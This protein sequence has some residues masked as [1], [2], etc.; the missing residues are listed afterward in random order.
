MPIA[1]IV[2]YLL[3]AASTASAGLALRYYLH[4]FQLN[5]YRPGAQLRWMA[6]NW[7]K[8]LLL[9]V[10]VAGGLFFWP[11]KAVKKPLVCTARVKRLLVTAALPYVLGLALPPL[12]KWVEYNVFHRDIAYTPY[13]LPLL[14]QF[15]YILVAPLA[16][17]F[18]LLVANLVNA[19]I[20]HA[21]RQHYINEAKEKLKNSPNLTV[22][23]IT[24]SYGKTSVK[25]FL[26]TL[27]RARFNVL[28]TPGGANVPM[29]VV[30]TVR[31]EL[32]A[33]HEIFICEMGA[34]YVGDIEELCG[35][36]H[37]RHG[38]LTSI[39][40]QHLETFGSQENVISTK[41]ELADA[42]PPGGILFANGDDA[43]IRTKLNGYQNV[44]TYAPFENGSDYHAE[45]IIADHRG[46]TFT[47]V[48]P[49]G[50]RET[51]TARLIGRHNVVNLVGAAAAA[52]TLGV[53]LRALKGQM[54]KIAPVR[55]RL[56]LLDKGGGLLVIDDAYNSN[57]TG[58]KAA[59]DALALFEGTKVL[60]TPGMIEL[61]PKQEE[62]NRKFGEQAA[63]VCDYIALVGAAQ[64]KPIREG[65]LAAG[66]AP[67]RLIVEDTLQAAM[68][69]VTA[70]P[71]DGR[72][73]ILLEN[74]LP[75]NY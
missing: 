4:M 75:D 26:H 11:R 35:I 50:E 30:R 52:H 45:D 17:P 27:L 57:P 44:V 40:P 38:I 73:I 41:F 55:H 21:I 37:P 53:P 61:G 34:K 58:A 51:F 13:L 49:Q 23:G 9:C 36:V 20:E 28:M 65:I 64:T 47:F 16:A 46:T 60:V 42:L 7:K 15:I 1:D 54:R 25:H 69:K 2:L 5:A 19:P 10:P 68:E 3:L 59:L 67:E 39:G 32:T 6:K 70:L 72:K 33:A 71:F 14:C 48:T 24:G 8:L 66:F 22:I 74:D 31:E 12:A 18:F 29:S 62:L 56:E 63:A 43:N